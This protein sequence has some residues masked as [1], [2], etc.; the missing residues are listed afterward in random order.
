V[1]RQRGVA[2]EIVLVIAVVLG[3]LTTIEVQLMLGNHKSSALTLLVNGQSKPKRNV[4]DPLA[5][6]ITGVA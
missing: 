2:T 5:T 3:V 6:R 4:T 1:G